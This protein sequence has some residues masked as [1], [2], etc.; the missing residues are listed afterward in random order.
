MHESYKRLVKI[1]E[2]MLGTSEPGALARAL[3]ESPQVV[4]NWRLRGVSKQGMLKAHEVFGVYPRYIATGNGAIRASVSTTP[5]GLSEHGNVDASFVG[6]YRIPLLDYLR[7][8]QILSGQDRLQLTGVVEWL[9]TDM[10]LT[11]GAFALEIKGHSMEPDFRQGDRV[12]IDPGVLPEPG[13]FVVARLNREAEATFKKYR[14]RGLTDAGQMIFELAPMHPDYAV[15]R[16]DVVP[17]SIVGTM[18]EHRRYRNR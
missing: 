15:I 4:S 10:K 13:D 2:E 14:L 6:T 12:I 3:G 5:K 9:L 11:G 18:V 17:I 16:S 7:A 8:G 1:S